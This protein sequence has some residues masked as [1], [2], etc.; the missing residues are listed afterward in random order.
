MVQCLRLRGS[1]AGAVGVVLGPG[2]KIPHARGVATKPNKRKPKK[3]SFL[4]QVS[5]I[6]VR[7]LSCII[8][9][10]A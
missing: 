10:V 9:V 2:T 3:T 8:A 4:S 7:M 6:Y 5:T 1:T